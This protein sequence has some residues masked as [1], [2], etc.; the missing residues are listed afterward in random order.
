MG[1]TFFDDQ[2]EPASIETPFHLDD[3]ECLGQELALED[4]VSNS[5]TSDCLQEFDEAGV[6][7]QP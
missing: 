2:F 5:D 6:L 4:C 1:L 3:V 7:C